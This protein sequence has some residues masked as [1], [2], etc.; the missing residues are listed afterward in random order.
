MGKKKAIRKKSAKRAV[1]KSTAKPSK[2][3]RAKKK[4]TTKKT[5]R[6]FDAAATA[7]REKIGS[8]PSDVL[9]GKFPLYAYRVNKEDIARQLE[10][11]A[12]LPELEGFLAVEGYYRSAA[13]FLL[14]A[15]DQFKFFS[16]DRKISKWVREQSEELGLQLSG[17][18]IG[19]FFYTPNSELEGDAV[20]QLRKESKEVF[21]LDNP[22]SVS[23]H[24]VTVRFG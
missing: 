12:G 1:K 14:A 10:Y 16:A 6:A 15:K 8:K 17:I 9:P 19:K 2:K 3:K 21:G 24:R 11:L 23:S 7:L 13:I 5:T 4:A 18:Q 22:I 20:K